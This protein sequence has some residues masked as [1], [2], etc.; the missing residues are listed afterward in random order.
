VHLFYFELGQNKRT[1]SK[2]VKLRSKWHFRT[3]QFDR[4]IRFNTRTHPYTSTTK[5]NYIFYG[6]AGSGY[7]LIRQLANVM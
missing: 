4:W 5:M 1:Q 3:V 6:C 2:L 7:E